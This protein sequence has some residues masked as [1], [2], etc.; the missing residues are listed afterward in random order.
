MPLVV[1]LSDSEIETFDL[2]IA[3][4][5]DGLNHGW[6]VREQVCAGR[7][8]IDQK[9]SLSDLYVEPVHWDVQHAG[10]LLRAQQVRGMLPSW[11]LLDEP[12]EASAIMR[13]TVI[14]RTLSAQL[15]VEIWT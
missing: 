5:A 2:V 15:G 9:A 11:P 14:G 13:W 4:L 6:R 12:L 7:V 10:E 3:Q 1:R 8:A